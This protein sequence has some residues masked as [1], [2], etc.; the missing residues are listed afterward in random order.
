MESILSNNT[1]DL[2]EFRMV[3]NPLAINGF[4]RKKKLELNGFIDKFKTS[5][6]AK[7]FI[8]KGRC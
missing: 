8:Q 1:W 4:S 2:T 7:E 3:A 6:V 5:L